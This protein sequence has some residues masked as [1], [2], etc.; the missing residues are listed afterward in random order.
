[1]KWVP[2]RELGESQRVAYRGYCVGRAMAS[3]RELSPSLIPR[4]SR[5]LGPARG[6][7]FS[8]DDGD[9]VDGED[10]ADELQSAMPWCV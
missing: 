7:A 6:C 10:D 8:V 3:R 2:V 5:V 4:R 1:M 9:D